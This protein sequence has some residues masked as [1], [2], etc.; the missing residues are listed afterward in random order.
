MSWSV[1]QTSTRSNRT[2]AAGS[3][4]QR[5]GL[6]DLLIAARESGILIWSLDADVTRMSRLGLVDR[7]EP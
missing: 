1:Y 6:G 4:G 2:G 5:F 7:Y 3:A